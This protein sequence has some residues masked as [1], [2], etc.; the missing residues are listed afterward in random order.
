MFNRQWFS[1][2]SQLGLSNRFLRFEDS[3]ACGNYSECWNLLLDRCGVV[4]KDYTKR[5]AIRL[6]AISSRRQDQP[7]LISFDCFWPGFDIMNSPLWDF[8]NA[9]SNQLGLKLLL[10]EDVES[11]DILFLSCFPSRNR[12]SLFTGATRVLVLGENIRPF[13]SEYDYSFSTDMPS[14]RGRNAYLPVWVHHVYSQ[15]EQTMRSSSFRQ[16]LAA[17]NVNYSE[18]M[19]SWNSRSASFVYVG[20]NNEPLRTSII[21]DLCDMG[22]DVQLYGSQTRPI[23]DK[24]ELYGS[25]QYILCPENSFYPGYVTEKLLDASLSGARIIYWGGVDQDLIRLLDSSIYLIDQYGVKTENFQK[26]VQNQYNRHPGAATILEYFN[27]AYHEINLSC[28]S[29]MERILSAYA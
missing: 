5:Q 1:A 19:R 3:L 7:V 4:C 20:N 29:L 15:S 27:R 13:Y 11:A 17:I 14:Y 28:I 23:L 24:Y 12:G 22:Y 9:A 26:Y 18:K 10:S 8:L 25:S 21:G 6:S 2:T 16:R